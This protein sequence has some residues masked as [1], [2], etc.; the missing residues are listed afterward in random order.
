VIFVID[1]TQQK[2]SLA[3]AAEVQ[4]SLL[5]QEAHL[6]EGLEIAG[7]TL[8]CDE[9]G[10]DYYDYLYGRE[11]P[12]DQFSVVVGDVTG[13]GVE[14]ALLMTT[15][16]AFLR[17]R[18]SQCGDISQIIT[19]MNR[20]LAH[21]VADS[22]RFMTL[23]VVRFDLRNRPIRWVRAGHPPVMIY[24]FEAMPRSKRKTFSMPSMPT[25]KPFRWERA[26]PTTSPS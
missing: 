2:R 9:I 5:P 24:D 8:S 18:A 23:S 15:A 13:H 14:A 12:E 25:S 20:Q 3:L 26:R 17:M 16:R 19:E 11:C 10:G 21:D 22:G 7:R 4:R 1:L 6:F